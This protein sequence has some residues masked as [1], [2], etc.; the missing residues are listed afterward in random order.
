MNGQSYLVVF[1]AICCISAAGISATTL[2]S[3]LSTDPDDVVDLDYKYLPFGKDAAETLQKEGE[4][5]QGTESS[6][7]ATDENQ[8]DPPTSEQSEAGQE[9]QEA[10]KQG[11]SGQS[12]G[13]GRGTGLGAGEAVQSLLDLLAKL[14]PFL[15]LLVALALAYRYRDRL[16]ALVLAVGGWLA[17]RAPTDAESRAA[18]WPSEQPANEV[19]RAWLAMVRRANPDRPWSRTPSE[20]A[21]AAVETGVDSETVETLTTLFEEVRYGDEPVTDERRERAREGLRRLDDSGGA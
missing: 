11:E 20:C 6:A 19:H 21:R 10:G 18:T 9:S 15:V 2:E 3:S 8:D 17:D 12:S 1:L 13:T 5:N 7:G 4:A 14:L 16:L